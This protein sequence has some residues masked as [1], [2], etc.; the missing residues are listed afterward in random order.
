[1]ADTS[2]P[3][4]TITLGRT[5][6]VVKRA[7]AFIERDNEGS[8][9]APV[10]G[11]KR[12]V[13]DRLGNSIDP[14]HFDNKRLRG[15]NG[16]WNSKA[17]NSVDDLH[18]SKGDLRF[19]IM[20]RTQSEGLKNT[21]DLREMLSRKSR[22]SVTKPVSPHSMPEVR[23]GRDREHDI[24]SDARDD[25]R[26]MPQPRDPRRSPE[27][28]NERQ[29]MPER[30]DR[31]NVADPRDE[32]Q[33]MPAPR[34]ER[35]RMPAPRDDRQR[36]QVPRDE[37]Q[38]MSMFRDDGHRM[39]E[40]RDDRQ[41]MAETRDGR[42][43]MPESLEVR[44]RIPKITD[45]RQ[46]Y[47]EPANGGMPSQYTSIRTSEGPS[48]SDYLRNS[49]SPW[50]LDHIRRKSPDGVPNTSMTSPPRRPEEQQRR[51]IIR[52]YEEPRPMAYT[53][54]DATE[55]SRPI[56]STSFLTKPSLSVGPTKPVGPLAAPPLPPGSN[57]QRPQ[58]PVEP[59]TVEGFLRSLGL[60]KYLIS[61]KVEEVDMPALS[62]M[63]DNDL[64]EMGIPMGPRKKI[65]LALLARARRQAR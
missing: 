8:D 46:R 13:K 61:F 31:Q 47:P 45:T 14:V 21:V 4:V 20:K 49:Y 40:S 18:L 37:K 65:L 35:Q 9:P 39:S 11:R 17:S 2:R 53:G 52:A 1:M 42:Q 24:T 33:R 23:H 30:R 59:T 51:P 41:M 3:Q 34:D 16:R 26:R 15:E 43:R 62:Q 28:R 12:P 29:N 44:Q 25:R 55:I 38:N 5:G 6:Q 54:R 58:Y 22:Q 27:P 19:K 36:M 32:R 64:K 57:M 50:T 60:E 7:G 48:Q 10:V 56:T 63:G